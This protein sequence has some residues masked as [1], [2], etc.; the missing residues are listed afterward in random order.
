MSQN[1]ESKIEEGGL[2]VTTSLDNSMFAME[3]KDSVWDPC[4]NCGR[5]VRVNGKC[6]YCTCGWSSCSI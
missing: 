3:L 4:P 6:K 2:V 1:L 5:Q